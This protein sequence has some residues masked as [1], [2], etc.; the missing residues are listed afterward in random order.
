MAMEESLKLR[1]SAE[2]KSELEAIQKAESRPSLGD[3]V[4]LLLKEALAARAAQ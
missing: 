2:L 4:R 1:L 3:V